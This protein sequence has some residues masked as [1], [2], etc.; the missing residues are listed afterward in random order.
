MDRIYM[1]EYK[2][3]AKVLVFISVLDENFCK[4]N[5]MIRNN[6]LLYM[7]VDKWAE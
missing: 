5:L 2:V 3:I 6:K 7:M 4:M 1:N